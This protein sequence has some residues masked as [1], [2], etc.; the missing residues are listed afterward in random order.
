[1][2]QGQSACKIVV[3]EVGEIASQL[4]AGEHA[5]VDDV[6][7]REGAEVEVVV[8]HAVLDALAYLI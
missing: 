7:A 6:L 1:M 8:V 5:L 4:S 3:R 2:N